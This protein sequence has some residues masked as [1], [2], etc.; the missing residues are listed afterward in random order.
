M[1]N[2]IKAKYRD[3][4]GNLN[5][6]AVDYIMQVQTDGLKKLVNYI[7]KLVNK[8]LKNGKNSDD[9]SDYDDIQPSTQRW[10]KWKGGGNVDGKP[11]NF[12]GNLSSKNK[13][14]LK[15]MK[16]KI[17]NSNPYS[18]GLNDGFTGKR[19]GGKLFIPARAHRKLPDEIKDDSKVIQITEEQ[20]MIDK[21]V[22][23]LLNL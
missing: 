18:R 4:D 22:K 3:K 9:G 17:E 2:I 5:K 19:G 15:N 8:R 1:I 21:I 23:E 12:T 11:L 10:R 13:T 14:T 20:K 7:N 6:K 16:I